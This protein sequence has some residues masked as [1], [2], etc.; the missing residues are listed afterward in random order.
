[1]TCVANNAGLEGYGIG[2]LIHNDQLKKII[3]SN[4]WHNEEIK[5]KFRQGK[6]E[7]EF[8]PQGTLA[9]RLRAAGAGI[10]A[11]YIPTGVGTMVEEGGIPIKYWNDGET[12]EKY[13][14]PKLTRMFDG[15]KYI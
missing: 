5:T 7:M 11:F 14:L 2:K 3:L 9:E 12:V 1:M 10:P 6:F 8:V 13:S 4:T 15:R